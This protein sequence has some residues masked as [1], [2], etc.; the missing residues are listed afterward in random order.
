MSLFRTMRV[1]AWT[2]LGG[3]VAVGLIGS[4]FGYSLQGAATVTV[5]FTA[6]VCFGL[7]V[8]KMLVT[9]VAYTKYGST[10]TRREHPFSYWMMVSV[11]VIGA[12]VALVEG[13]RI[14]LP[15][16]SSKSAVRPTNPS[17]PPSNP[18]TAPQHLPKLS[19]FRVH[20]TTIA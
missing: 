7:E 2:A 15:L 12:F 6:G 8:A 5:M 18:A 10:L 9:G 19:I 11:F 17:L 13:G 3:E 20:F 16:L 1:S 4:T 14:L